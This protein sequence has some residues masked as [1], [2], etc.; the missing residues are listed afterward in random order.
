MI[1]F[2]ALLIALLL[3]GCTSSVNYEEMLEVLETEGFYVSARTAGRYEK[4]IIVNIYRPGEPGV[5]FEFWVIEGLSRLVTMRFDRCGLGSLGIGYIQREM[6]PSNEE[7]QAEI[8][9]LYYA[10]WNDFVYNRE[11]LVAFAGWFA[12]QNH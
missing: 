11:E 2:M 10:F 5:F 4:D 1:A 7:E 8:E 12:G 6:R 9:E 3:V